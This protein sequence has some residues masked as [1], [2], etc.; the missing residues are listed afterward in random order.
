[1][2]SLLVAPQHTCA[3]A[4]FCTSCSNIFKHTPSRS[5][6]RYCWQR[7]STCPSRCCKACLHSH[8]HNNYAYRYIDIHLRFS[9]IL[10]RLNKL[11]GRVACSVFVC[12]LKQIKRLYTIL[13]V[14]V[15]ACS[16]CVLCII[17]TE[18][19]Q[20]NTDAPHHNTIENNTQH[21]VHFILMLQEKDC[22]ADYARARAATR[23]FMIYL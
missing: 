9:L 20:K 2:P 14:C 5:H 12:I 23:L 13:T 18:Y 11:C 1:M 7:K 16:Y 22:K 6:L 3:S 15:F 8:R 21:C 10:F 17:E 4:T 19:Y